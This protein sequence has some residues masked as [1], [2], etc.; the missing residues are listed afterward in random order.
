MKSTPD[1]LQ[2]AV[3]SITMP[4]V[5]LLHEIPFGEALYLK[6]SPDGTMLAVTGRYDTPPLQDFMERYKIKV[7]RMPSGQP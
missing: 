3:Q 4:G 5:R 7:W 1:L 2:E 6:F